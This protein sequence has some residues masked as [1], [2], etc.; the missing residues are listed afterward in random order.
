LEG[1]GNDDRGRK[2]ITENRRKKK[3]NALYTSMKLSKNK[4]NQ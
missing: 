2:E 1:G 4:F 3:Q